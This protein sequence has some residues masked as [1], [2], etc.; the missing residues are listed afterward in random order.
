MNDLAGALALHAH[1]YRRFTEDVDVLLTPTVGVPPL[2]IGAYELSTLQ[3]QGVK[4][5]AALPAGAFLSQRAKL[6]EAF[7]RVF[8]AAP[9]TMIANVTGQ[10]S[11]SLPLH[12]TADG[13]PMGM[14]FTA[15]T[16][17]EATLLRLAAQ[18]EQ[19]MPWKDRRPPHA[20]A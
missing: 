8:E 1:G 5:L 16:G 18:V 9:Y 20:A 2:P 14:L 3:R 7:A 6:I 12:W 17:D 19:A 15:R 13:L 4:L 11:M 10:P